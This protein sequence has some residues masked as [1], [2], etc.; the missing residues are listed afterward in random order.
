MKAN[1]LVFAASMTSQT[2]TPKRSHS[3]AISLIKLMLMKR[4]VF[5][6][7]FEVSA[8]SGEL[9]GT[10]ASTDQPGDP[11]T[12]KA[13][14]GLPYPTIKSLPLL[15]AKYADY[16][17]RAKIQ[18]TVYELLTEQYELAKVQE[19]KETPSVKVLDPATIPEK[20]SFPPRLLIMFLA[21]LLAAGGSVVWVLGAN[22]WQQADPNDPRKILARE[23]VATVKACAPWAR[24]NGSGGGA[25]SAEKKI[26]KRPDSQSP[27]AGAEEP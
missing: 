22:Q 14:G 21:T 2:F 15:G 27:S 24:R 17:R 1:G 18:E 19:A 23:V 12:A 4:N 16:Y 20:K 26:L 6:T 7:S 8:T 9:T 11:S 25:R 10:S 13:G 3:N 5:S